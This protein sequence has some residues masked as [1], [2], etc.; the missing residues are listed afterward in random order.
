[1]GRATRFAVAAAGAAADREDEVDD[2]GGGEVNLA[3][4]EEDVELPPR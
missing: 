3:E 2:V 1:M 4:E